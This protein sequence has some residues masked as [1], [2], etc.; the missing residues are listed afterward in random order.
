[1]KIS[2]VVSTFSIFILTARGQIPK[3]EGPSEAFQ[4]S[5]AFYGLQLTKFGTLR[6]FDTLWSQIILINLP[7][8]SDYEPLLNE[9]KAYCFSLNE[10]SFGPV[11][12][13]TGKRVNVPEAAIAAHG[14]LIKACRG[15]E[16]TMQN[17]VKNLLHSAFSETLSNARAPNDAIVDLITSKTERDYKL[18]VRTLDVS[19]LDIHRQHQVRNMSMMNIPSTTRRPL[20]NVTASHDVKNMTEE[21]VTASVTTDKQSEMLSTGATSPSAPLVPTP[22]PLASSYDEVLKIANQLNGIN[23]DEPVLKRDKRFLITGIALACVSLLSASFGA[24]GISLQNSRKIQELESHVARLVDVNTNQDK[25]DL[26]LVDSMIGL[27]ADAETKYNQSGTAIEQIMKLQRINSAHIRENHGLLKN[28][29]R[30]DTISNSIMLHMIEQLDM[31]NKVTQ[32]LNSA[33]RR[34][35]DYETG[36]ISLLNSQMS[37]YFLPYSKLRRILFNVKQSLPRELQLAISPADISLYYYHRLTTFAKHDNTL[38]LRLVIPLSINKGY[39]SPEQMYQPIYHSVPQPRIFDPN[40]EQNFYRLYSPDNEPWLYSKDRFVAQVSM[41]QLSCHELGPLRDCIRFRPTITLPVTKC[42][43][44]IWA[45]EFSPAVLFDKADPY[46]FTYQQDVSTYHPIRIKDNLYLIHG[47]SFLSYR[48]SCPGKEDDILD[49]GSDTA[50]SPV[51]LDEGCVLIVKGAVDEERVY[52]G[53]IISRQFNVSYSF[54]EG[55]SKFQAPTAEN[56]IR[57]SAISPVP[58]VKVNTSNVDF[59]IIKQS[60]KVDTIVNRLK[61]Q[62]VEIEERISQYNTT[63]KSS[64]KPTILSGLLRIIENFV[65]DMLVILL[66]IAS[67]RNGR[68]MFFTSPTII[69]ANTAAASFIDPFVELFDTSAFSIEYYEEILTMIKLLFLALLLL[70]FIFRNM[71]NRIYHLNHRGQLRSVVKNKFVMKI[72]FTIERNCICYAIKEQYTI[73]C[74]AN[75]REDKIMSRNIKLFYS[76]NSQHGWKLKRGQFSLPEKVTVKGLNGD[77]DVKYTHFVP[78]CFDINSVVWATAGK[79]LLRFE[80]SGNCSVEIIKNPNDGTRPETEL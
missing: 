30:A 68:M 22:S 29:S 75:I 40:G 60:S 45:N 39:I 32:I 47:S 42:T 36:L 11:D 56:R 5:S 46:C 18:D 54:F 64:Y 55:T 2:L 79:K 20:L 27:T 33:R 34:I 31:T 50:M 13:I 73:L 7:R 4:K 14:Q 38:V 15:F 3:D 77:M 66:L 67:F 59:R 52:P 63:F 17:T 49:V 48:R 70:I 74:P 6:T 9:L 71:F 53:P 43:Q 10:D 37:T 28:L 23:N 76:L 62:A 72:E 8:Y 24:W 12:I 41:K 61:R 58:L 35:R 16:R 51:E 44:K 26:I 1:M 19:Q 65:F 25:G 80:N 21:N 69:F 78:I 57:L